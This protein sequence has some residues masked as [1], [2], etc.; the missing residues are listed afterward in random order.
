MKMTERR[1]QMRKNLAQG[2]LLLAEHQSTEDYL[3]DEIDALEDTQLALGKELVMVQE[4]ILD[5]ES[6]ITVREIDYYIAY[7]CFPEDE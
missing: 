2:S 6:W 5:L 7:G 3:E 1:N 4:G